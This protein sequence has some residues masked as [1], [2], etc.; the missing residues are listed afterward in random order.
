MKDIVLHLNLKA[1]WFEMI[2]SGEK[3]EEYRE[4]KPYW[5]KRFG[6]YIRIKGKNYHPTDVTICFSNGYHKNAPRVY[7]E[8]TGLKQSPGKKEWGAEVGE[9]YHVL[10]L[11]QIIK[12]ENSKN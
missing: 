1:K 9:W 4:I 11:G 2:A 10:L 5:N 6:S 8:C 12:V 3:K 7:M